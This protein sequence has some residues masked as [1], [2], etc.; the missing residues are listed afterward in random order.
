[1]SVLTLH[2]A[3]PDAKAM[4]L[5]LGSL[6]GGALPLP[7]GWSVM[8]QRPRAGPRSP[9]KLPGCCRD[10]ASSGLA[11]NPLNPVILQL[12][13]TPHRSSPLLG[14]FPEPRAPF[15]CST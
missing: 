6:R 12:P 13:P 14:P 1:M 2:A 7:P 5:S 8:V 3:F 4:C 11:G 9:R 10:Q 15:H